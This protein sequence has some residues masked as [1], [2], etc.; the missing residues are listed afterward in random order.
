MAVD[1]EGDHDHQRQKDEAGPLGPK[2]VVHHGEPDGCEL[3]E[4]HQGVANKVHRIVGP[5]N[6]CGYL[7]EPAK[8]RPHPDSLGEADVLDGHGVNDIGKS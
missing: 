2:T 3:K 4:R 5:G 8:R 6:G 7:E 1:P